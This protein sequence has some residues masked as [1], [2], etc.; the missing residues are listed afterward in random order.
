M[1]G[2]FSGTEV[3]NVVGVLFMRHW[4]VLRGEGLGFGFEVGEGGSKER[5]RVGTAIR[6]VVDD[7]QYRD[8][9]DEYDVSPFAVGWEIG[10]RRAGRRRDRP[11]GVDVA[12]RVSV[13]ALT[14]KNRLTHCCYR[15]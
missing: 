4:R 6:Q 9:G 1:A 15:F 2:S 13:R 11:W 5:A 3:T 14:M 8:W 10:E 7:G 12:R